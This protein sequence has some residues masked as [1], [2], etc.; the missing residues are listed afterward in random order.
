[1][2]SGGY[3]EGEGGGTVC[4]TEGEERRVE[5]GSGYEVGS[6]SRGVDGHI[7]GG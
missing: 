6:V 4:G 2:C 3:S 1:M 5:W 7:E